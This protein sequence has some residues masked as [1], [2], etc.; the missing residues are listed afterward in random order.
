[1]ALHLGKI[2]IFTIFILFLFYIFFILLI[3]IS[4]SY[5]TLVL[6]H[7]DLPIT[8]MKKCDRTDKQTNKQ[9]NK[10]TLVFVEL[11]RN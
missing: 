11:L 7:S 10:Q 9:T 2:K 8:S 5:L 6:F 3:F 4:I 1:M